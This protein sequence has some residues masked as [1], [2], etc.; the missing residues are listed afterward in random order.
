VVEIDYLMLLLMMMLLLLKF[1]VKF[2][3]SEFVGVVGI[4]VV[5]VVEVVLVV[6]I[7]FLKEKR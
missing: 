2:G 7:T 6:V 4:G 3:L 5:V 1:G